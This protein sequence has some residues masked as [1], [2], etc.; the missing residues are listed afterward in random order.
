MANLYVVEQGAYLRKT[1]ER[2][3]VQKDDEVLVDVPCLQLESVLLF[4]NVQC[5]TQ[6]LAE[7][8]EH[9]IELALLSR[10]GRLRGQLTPPKA[11]NVVLR[12]RQYE[13]VQDAGF[14]LGVA[15]AVVRAKLGQQ[16]AL[17]RNFRTN[18]PERLPGLLLEDLASF[19]DAVGRA[20]SLESLRGAEGSAARLYFE[21]LAACVPEEF[22]FEGRSRRPP[23]DPFNA[24]LS[25]GYVLI[26]NELQSLL[27]AIGFDP[28]LGFLHELDYGRPSLALDLLEEFR[29]AF[30]DRLS[31]SLV[32]LGHLKREHF[33]DH[34]QRGVSLTQ[35]GLKKYFE[36]YDRYLMK[37]WR[38][39]GKS[40]TSRDLFRQ[41][42][43]RLARVI[44][45]DEV[46]QGIAEIG[47]ED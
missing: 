44:Q 40:I 33:E 2:L 23:R 16:V 20:S 39:G 4:G 34:P 36:Q 31:L 28:Y 11:K 10:S 26:G 42:A 13:R 27:D 30:V 21:L 38:V 14:C 29:P 5:S 19:E 41:Q 3:I 8:L 9:G 24:L 17:L 18:H 37:P 25:F 6:A 12:M 45:G 15:K 22:R 7:L 1:S 47:E 32:N 43:H 35:E 46:F